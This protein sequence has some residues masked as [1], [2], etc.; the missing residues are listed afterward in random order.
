VEFKQGSME[1]F[2]TSGLFKGIYRGRRV[3]IT[4]N[5]GFKGSWLQYW[6]NEMGAV[7]TGFALE[8]STHPAHSDLLPKKNN[9]VIADIRDTP[10]I[11]R[12]IAACNPEIVFHLAAQP[13]VRRSYIDPLETFQ[14]NIIGTAN[15]LEAIRNQASV[16]ALVNITTDKVYKVDEGAEAFKEDARLGGYDPYSTSKACVELMHESYQNS[17]YSDAGIYSATAR[18]GNVIGGGDWAKDRLIPD[19][20]RAA[21]SGKTASIRNPD[22]IRPWQHV[23]DPLSGYLLLGQH[24]LEGNQSA[25]GAWNFGPDLNDC[26]PVNQVLDLFHKYWEDIQWKEAVEISAPKE[27]AILRLD[28]TKSKK[29]L[30]WV[31]I[32][33]L[34]KAIQKT[35]FWYA[36]FYQNGKL[37]T[38]DNLGDYI[39]DAR[40]ASAPWTIV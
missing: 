18:A 14:T 34:E 10:S 31:P 24:L 21:S 6:L 30:G 11:Q 27:S 40:S 37:Q 13:L 9:V 19:L 12:A 23:L 20:V 4:G 39:L 7:C 28:C 17:F 36:G 5:T 26:R 22:S 25:L 38:V 33:S 35:A 3:L 1:D 15:L 2:V 8:P 29:E 32:W 16:K